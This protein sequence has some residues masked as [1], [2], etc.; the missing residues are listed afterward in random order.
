MHDRAPHLALTSC[1]GNRNQL[2]NTSTTDR[3][4]TEAD[5]GSSSTQRSSHRT[6]AV[7]QHANCD[8]TTVALEQICAT[9]SKQAWVLW[10]PL[11]T[12]FPLDAGPSCGGRFQPWV[13]A[14]TAAWHMGPWDQDLSLSAPMMTGEQ[15][16]S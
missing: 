3:L 2:E 14:I 6:K 11:S 5:S 8:L 7:C 4:D 13:S 16:T 15:M 1:L 10:L 9:A 12:D